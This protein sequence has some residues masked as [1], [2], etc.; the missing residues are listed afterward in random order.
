V[1]PVFHHPWFLWMLCWLVAG[2]ALCAWVAGR[3]NWRGPPSWLTL[4]PARWL[5]LVPLTMIPQWFMGALVPHFGPDTSAGLLPM[6]HLLAYYAIFFA[7]G[8][9][10]FDSRDDEGRLGRR[11]AITLPVMLLVVFPV[12]LALTGAPGIRARAADS[13]MWRLLSAAVQVTYAWAMS[14]AFIGLF[15]R[16]VPRESRTLRYISDSSYWLYL[17]HLPL[18]IVAQALVRDWPLPGVV[19]FLLI[20]VVVTGVLLL[21]YQFM[22]RYTWIGAL[23]NGRRRRPVKPPP[24]PMP[25]MDGAAAQPVEVRVR[26]DA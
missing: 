21:T 16:I 26:S 10:Y 12:G 22:V 11:W 18:V 5:W 15:R 19:K 25:T 14:F 17:A 8:A 7:F 4:S 23:L 9:L 3:L 6:P 24:L 2:F 20:C 1:L 13:E